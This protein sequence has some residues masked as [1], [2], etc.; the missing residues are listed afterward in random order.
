M[1]LDE[2]RLVHI[3]KFRVSRLARD[4]Q[5]NSLRRHINILNAKV[6]MAFKHLDMYRHSPL[7]YLNICGENE[8]SRT[9]APITVA[10][11]R[12]VKAHLLSHPIL[13]RLAALIQL[14]TGMRISEPVLASLD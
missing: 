6:D 14:N 1:P 7:R 2:L 13:S 3:T 9:M 8:L 10:H 5:A 4:L 12:K 11:L